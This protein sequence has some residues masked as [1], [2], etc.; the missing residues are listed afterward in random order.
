MNKLLLFVLLYGCSQLS[1]KPQSTLEE[2]EVTVDTALDQA[3]A[4]YLKGCVDAFHELKIAPAFGQCMD[5]AILHREE[6]QG[7]MDQPPH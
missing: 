3:R 6:I 2:G 5:K 1:P 7:I 4:S